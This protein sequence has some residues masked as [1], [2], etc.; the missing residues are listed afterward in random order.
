[1]NSLNKRGCDSENFGTRITW[2]GVTGEKIWK[3]EVLGAKL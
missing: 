2:F 3:K 1:M